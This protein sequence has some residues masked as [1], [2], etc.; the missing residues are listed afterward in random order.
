[1]RKV[2]FFVVFLATFALLL[3]VWK[4]TPVSDWYIAGVLEFAGAVGPPLHGWVLQPGSVPTWVHG[5][6]RVGTA[7]QFDALA[8]GVVP[9]IALLTATP[10]LRWRRRSIRMVVGTATL[11][12][13]DGL[14]VA[15]FPLLVFYKNAFTDVIGTFLGLV[16]FVGAPVII[17]FGLTFHELRDWLPSLASPLT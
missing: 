6:D 5:A 14:L 17:W 10:G 2:R 7:I 12:L 3:V 15:L 11:L 4:S 16:A 1:M 13:V 8:V 9:L